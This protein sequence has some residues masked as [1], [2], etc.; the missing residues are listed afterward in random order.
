MAAKPQ[1]PKPLYVTL[2]AP[3]GG[4]NARDSIAKMPPLDAVTLIN[5]F[6]STTS[7]NL[8]YGYSKH[9][10]GFSGLAQTLMAYS[11]AATSKL[12]TVT[13]AGN[14]YDVTSAGAV[15]AA[16]VTGLTNGKW[17]YENIANPTAPYLMGVNG[18]DK[19]V[20]YTGSAWA[21]D[22]DGPPYDITG[23]DSSTW[24]DLEC[25]K[26]RVWGIQK[27]TLKAWYL[28]TAA[29]GGAAAA[30]DL[31][32]FASKGGSLQAI[33]TWTID[34]GYGMDDYLVF[35]TSKG[36]IIVY[37]GTDP[38][39]AS[40]W[41]LRG[42]WNIGSPVGTRCLLKWK[43]DLLIICQDGVMPLSSALQSSR[44]NPR[45][46]LTD[47][48]QYAMST[49]VTNYGATF[50]WQLV[51]FPKQNMLFMNVPVGAE[52]TQEQYAMNT[53]TGSWGQFQGW[54]AQ[55]WEVFNDEIYFGSGTYV[56]HAWNTLA[57]NGTNIPGFIIQAFNSFG[58][59]AQRKR[60][61]AMRP[62]I[63]TNGAPNIQCSM[64][65][66]FDTSNPTSPLSFTTPSYGTWDSGLWDTAIWGADLSPFYAL[67]G[68]TGSGHFGA[69]VFKSLSNGIQVQL[70]NNDISLE[71]GN[72][73]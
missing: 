31:S 17:Q 7:V 47:K 14:I 16:A 62:Y 33:G 30:L 41:A 28:P 34:A 35:V 13:S 23:G 6:P 48:I 53:I 71:A 45:V 60:G 61:T 57:D 4:W 43:G 46:A 39:S 9:G 12:F 18:V 40:T 29:I 11:G 27:N 44:V 5:Y 2:S 26:N 3:V 65:W 58:K 69:P 10:T 66:D 59:P 24:I 49:A 63:L 19:A 15:G 22:G 38:S 64:N 52:T 72:F 56:G 25:F 1:G 42:V 55:C 51:S 70:V 54:N 73:L 67:Q 20:F 32:A 50:G 68:V 8:R 37:G 36:Q 21:R